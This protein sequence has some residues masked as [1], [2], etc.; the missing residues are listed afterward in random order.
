MRVCRDNLDLELSAASDRLPP[1]DRALAFEIA[2]GTVRFL[3]Q[4][5]A[6]LDAC[7][8]RPLP[9]GKAFVRAILQTALYQARHLRVPARAAVNEAVNLIKRSPDRHQAGFVNAVLR[10]AVA[11]D[12]ETVLAR[13]A[14]PLAR[15]AL[16][17]AHPEWLVR[18]W[19]EV[20]DPETL[21]RR[22][23]A[24]NS[25]A[26]LTLRVNR[27][28][29]DPGTV[30]AALGETAR[31]ARHCPDGLILDQGG[32][33]AGLPGFEQGWFA[34]QDQAAQLVSILLAPRPG[35][36][37]LDACAAPGGKTAH[38]AAL[39]G[40]GARITAVEKYPG[41]LR[42][43]HDNLTRLG[44]DGVEIVV[45]DAGDPALL[46]D[47]TF[48]RALLDVPCSATG[49]IRRHP[50]IK[51]RR[52]PGDVARL[53]ARQRRILDAVAPRVRPGGVLVYATCSLEPEENADQIDRFLQDNPAWRR[54]P[55]TAAEGIAE[56]LISDA[57]DFRTEPGEMDG[58]FASRLERLGAA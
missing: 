14:D 2:T 57:G 26:P 40:G 58:F 4:L 24:N 29:S 38:L 46:A 1:R 55:P 20:V 21:T 11:L 43:L 12:P 23:Q 6:Q 37:I 48:D 19:A 30:Q 9:R 32:A 25:P 41:R 50:E 35:E 54:Q 56:A 51:W 44:V 7:M 15:L 28:R 36:R 53:A 3:S 5:D 34:V 10:Q 22:L 16:E 52:T 45:G 27:L 42:R 33:V 8:N 47:K 39:A 31:P 18:R 49:V 17:Q 13:I